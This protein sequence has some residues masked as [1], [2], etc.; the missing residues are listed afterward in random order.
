[1]QHLA[2]HLVLSAL[3][4]ELRARFGAYELA[5]HWKQGEFHH[6]LI[7]RLPETAHLPGRFLVISTNCNGGI[8]EILCLAEMPTRGGLWKLRCPTNPEFEGSVP[9]VLDRAVTV[10]WFDPCE[11]LTPGA[12][13]EYRAEC[14]IRQPGGGWI[15]SRP[16]ALLARGG[17]SSTQGC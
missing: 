15:A 12:R 6:D 3:L 17:E 7:V 10:H 8:K 11:L 14:R 9:V 2:D 5:T 16:P 13:S 1:M 4:D